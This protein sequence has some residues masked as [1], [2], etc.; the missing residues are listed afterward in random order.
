MVSAATPIPSRAS[1]PC[2]LSY[3]AVLGRLS[4]YWLECD[5]ESKDLGT[6]PP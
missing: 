4:K 1:S 5:A 6:N 3:V 2:A